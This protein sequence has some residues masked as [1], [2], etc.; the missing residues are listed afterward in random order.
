MS[1]HVIDIAGHMQKY[2]ETDSIF[3]SKST[4]NR[5]ASGIK[6]GFVPAMNIKVDGLE[7]YQWKHTQPTSSYT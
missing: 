4:V 6:E 5:L 3:L 1:E 2:A 7:V